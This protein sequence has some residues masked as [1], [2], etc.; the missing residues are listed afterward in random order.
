[1]SQC[2]SL[3]V[4]KMEVM[5]VPASCCCGYGSCQVSYMPG[6]VERFPAAGCAP[7]SAGCL[8]SPVPG[9]LL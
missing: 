9:F 4:C 2:L 5:I 7:S 3:L 8:V 6:A 1:M